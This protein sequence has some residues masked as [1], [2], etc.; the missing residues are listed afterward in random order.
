[1]AREIAAADPGIDYIVIGHHHVALD[2]Q[3]DGMSTRLIVLGD[4]ITNDTYAVFDGGSMSLRRFE[5]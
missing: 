5:Q 2:R 3:L 4:W 1:M